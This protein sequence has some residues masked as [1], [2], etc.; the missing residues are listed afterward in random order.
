[1]LACRSLTAAEAEHCHK[2]EEAAANTTHTCSLD[3]MLKQ[4]CGRTVAPAASYMDLKLNNGTYCGLLWLLFGDHCDYYKEL[5]KIYRIPNCKE[6]FTIRNAYT[7]EI[8]ARITWAII[9][10]GRSFFGQNPVVSDFAPGSYFLFST[11]HL[12]SIT[13][14][15][16][17]AIPIQRAMFIRKWMVSQPTIAVLYGV[18]PP[19]EPPAQWPTPAPAPGLTAP[20]KPPQTKEDIHHPQIKLLMDPYLKRHN[21]FIGLLEIL[22][23]CRKCLTDLPTLP[24]YCHPTGQSFLCW[25]SMLGKCFRGSQCKYSKG[26]AKIGNFTNAFADAVSDCI[27]KGVLYYGNLPEGE[28]SPNRKHRRGGGGGLVPDSGQGWVVVDAQGGRSQQERI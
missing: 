24:Q 14:S 4:N 1:M 25:N 28:G 19:G 2:Y 18:P 6:C 3:D 10:D 23:A 12:Q 8:C 15:V 20:T 13:D 16:Q 26:R 27:S 17:N 9:D 5:L 21:N 11:S 7:K 22:T